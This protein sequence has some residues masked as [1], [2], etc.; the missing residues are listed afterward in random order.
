M[1]YNIYNGTQLL[2]FYDERLWSN[3]ILDYTTPMNVLMFSIIPT[4]Y[5]AYNY[6]FNNAGKNSVPRWMFES[7]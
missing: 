6:W 7:F 5:P 2:L 3:V 1:N 4:S